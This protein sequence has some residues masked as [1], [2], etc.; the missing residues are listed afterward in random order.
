MSGIVGILNTDGAPVS[1]DLIG[2]MAQVLRFR[3]P[4]AQNLWCDTQI[5][6]GHTLFETTGRGVV[7]QQPCS[8][9][10]RVWIVADCR[11]DARAELWDK[12]HSSSTAPLT[13]FSDAKLILLAYQ[14]WGAD[15]LHHLIGDFAFAIWDGPK[16]QLFCARDHF[17]VKPFYYANLSTSFI[18]SNTLNCLRLHPDV[19]ADLNDLAISDY[20]LF[21][22]GQDT[23]TTS[24]K[25]LQR[26]PPGHFLLSSEG[27]LKISRYWRLRP[28]SELRYKKRREY[29][30]NFRSLLRTAVQDRLPQGPVSVFMSGGLDSSTIAATVRDSLGDDSQT[31]LRAYSAVYHRLIPDKE[32]DYASRVAK[33]RG[34]P[35]SFLVAD[36]YQ[37]FQHWQERDA[38]SMEPCDQ[39]LSGVDRDL[40]AQIAAHARV[41][42]T[43]EGGD[44]CLVPSSEAV[45]E[46]LWAGKFWELAAGY[47]RCARWQRSIPKAGLRTLIRARTIS[48][49]G[50]RL[51]EWINP[52]LAVKLNLASRERELEDRMGTVEH[53]RPEAFNSLSRLWW[54]NYFE[55]CDPGNRRQLVETRHP[56]FDIRLVTFL[57]SLPTVPWCI[58]KQIIR[59]AMRG[60]L[61]PEIIRRRKTPLAG[62]PVAELLRQPQS[63]W[64]DSFEPTPQLLYY[65]DRARV[66][67]LTG[68]KHSSSEAWVHLRPLTLNHWLREQVMLGYKS[69]I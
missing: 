40:Y 55:L 63:A 50:P 37:L 1:R 29:L 15:C 47:S 56:F 44:P 39:P 43:G 30:E 65:V 45:V 68:K 41:V 69:S 4:D 36:D 10:G 12:L 51:P 34:I 33:F 21:G 52:E 58:G 25:Q 7:D 11:I 22:Y 24:F 26:L 18:F 14:R 59:E 67:R 13:D 28:T 9:D 62:N 60:I 8:L 2:S 6:L 57:L 17:G 53:R 3:G 66:P 20:L 32:G 64:I 42:L 46:L 31:R 5:A 23:G 19:S 61:P 38:G 27:S 49:E 54:T 16:K 48:D 35:L